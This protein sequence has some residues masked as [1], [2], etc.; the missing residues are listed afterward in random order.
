MELRAETTVIPPKII[1]NKIEE[2]TKEIVSKYQIGTVPSDV[3]SA[4]DLNASSRK[5]VSSR[6]SRHQSYQDCQTLDT[7]FHSEVDL[8]EDHKGS[9]GSS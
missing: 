4:Y 2:E 8:N 9:E 7:H 3:D 1:N 6:N 5:G